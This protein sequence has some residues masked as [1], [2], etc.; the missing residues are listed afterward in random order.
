LS[1]VQVSEIVRK[2]SVSEAESVSV[3]R[4]REGDTYSVGPLR[5][6]QPPQSSGPVI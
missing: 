2:L 6:V 4:L 5:K 1:S 3:F